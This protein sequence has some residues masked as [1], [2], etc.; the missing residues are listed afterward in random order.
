[1]YVKQKLTHD[2][3]PGTG[4]DGSV[5][6]SGP[7]LALEDGVIA[8]ADIVDLER[9]LAGVVWS[10]DLVPRKARQISVVSCEKTTQKKV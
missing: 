8:E 1:M 4:P 10:K 3:E 2:V 6:E 9:V 7:D 5:V